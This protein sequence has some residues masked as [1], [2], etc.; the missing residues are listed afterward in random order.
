VSTSFL[1]A[2]HAAHDWV[3]RGIAG[4]MPDVALNEEGRQQAQQL[5]ER[6]Q[7]VRIDAIYCSPQPR[8]QQTA[9]PLADARRLAW[10]VQPAFDEVDMGEWQGRSFDELRALGE[11]WQHWC[12]RRGS[13]WP[14]GGEP[15]TDVPRRAIAGLHALR[16]EHPDGQVLVVSHGDVIK[17]IVAGCLGMSLDELERFDIAP[18]SVSLLSLGEGWSRLEL[19]NAQGPLR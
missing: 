3:G 16:A 4:R 19:L 12:E 6:L 5:V 9:Q 15:F 17:A 1:L 2:R 18:A 8:T 10:R 11:P 7:G 13:A 14:P